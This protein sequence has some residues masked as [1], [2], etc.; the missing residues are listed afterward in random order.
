MTTA[1]AEAPTPGG[2]DAS[3]PGVAAACELMETDWSPWHMV[4]YGLTWADYERLLAARQAA[5]RKRLRITYD[6]G[7]AEIMTP[8]GGPP[9]PQP[10]ARPGLG[11]E[12]AAV[13]TVGNRHERWKKLIAR[14]IE[15]AAL[16]F[17]IPLVASGNLTLNRP[18]L[19]RGL[20][21]DECY[22]VR[23]T[24]RVAAVRELD[25]RTD[26]VPDLVVEVEVSRTVLDR[27]DLYTALGIAEV[28]RFDG[29]RVRFLVRSETGGYDETPANLAFPLLTA[30]GLGGYLA[31]AGTV[32]DTTLCLELME[33]ARQAAPRAPTP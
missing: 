4:L 5:G 28:W 12:G 27:L 10:E 33:W 18:G 13:M 3:T 9:T 32:D 15:A 23:N 22:Y 30:A 20:E 29:D 19:D 17:R 24:T 26:P 16:G 2:P 31:R 6:R 7:T 11:R 1:T 14:L 21:P 25:F 8:G